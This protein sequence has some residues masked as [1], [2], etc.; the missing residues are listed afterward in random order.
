MT[1]AGREPA[2]DAKR[3]FRRAIEFAGLKPHEVRM[4]KMHQIQGR[5]IHGTAFPEGWPHEIPAIE[6]ITV[7]RF[8]GAVDEVQIR[9]C[10][11]DGDPLMETFRA[12]HVQQCSCDLAELPMT[13]KEVWAARCEVVARL[14]QG[15][16]PPIFDGRWN[17]AVTEDL[18]PDM[19]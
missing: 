3:I 7:V 18:L 6:M 16:V 2:E 9:C 12:P 10:A 1:R 8:D 14:A 13:L 15:E 17:W 4:Y 11:T 5:L 19:G